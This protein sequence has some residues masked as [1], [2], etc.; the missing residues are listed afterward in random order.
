MLSDAFGQNADQKWSIGLFGGKTEYKG[1]IGNGFFKYQPFYQLGGL[2]INHYLNPSFDIGIQ[3][4]TGA[5]GFMKPYVRSF[6]SDKTDGSLLLRYKLN[7]GYIF[8]EDAIIAPYLTGGFGFAGFS[9]SRTKE[10]ELD[11]ILPLGGGIKVNLSHTV[12]LQYQLLYN[13][14]NGDNRDLVVA[15]KNDKFIA[16]T[17]GLIFSF[18]SPKDADKDGVADK[19]DKCPGTPEGVKVTLNGCPVDGDNDGI[20][21]YLDKCPSVAGIAAFTGCPDSDGDGVQDSQDKCLDV[22]G[23]ASL[24]GCPDSDGDGITDANDKCPNVK[25]LAAFSGCPDTDGDGITDS[26]DRC[27][28]VKGPKELKGCPDGDN[29]GIADIDDKCPTV[30]GIV[31]NKGCPEIKEETKEVFTKALT[32]ILFETGKDVIKSSSFQ[33]LNNIVTIL[34]E[35]PAYNLNIDGHTDAVGDDA[36]NLDLSQRRADAVKKYLVD[37]GINASRL[38]A[39]GY[40]EAMPVADN[41]T[42]AGRAKNRRVEFK[43]IF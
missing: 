32:G 27:P 2:A 40:G 24:D 22:K 12:A 15:G 18:G 35:N 13:L 39:E 36:R 42:S 43:V 8:K 23:L 1:D 19:L 16:H 7:N 21:D 31:A 30:Y 34:N 25:G 11:G 17:L 37:N 28:N 5:Y 14:T 3:G 10:G 4:E 20:A 33:I 38:T 9:G 29:D 41:K 6:L 26:E